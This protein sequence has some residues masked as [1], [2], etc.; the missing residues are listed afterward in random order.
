MCSGR[1]RRRPTSP[2]RRSRWA[3]PPCGSSSAS[4]RPRHA[5]LPTPPACSMWRTAVSWSSSAALGCTRPSASSP[6][7]RKSPARRGRLVA[8]GVSAVLV[9][10]VEAVVR[11]A[12]EVAEAGEDQHDRE[13][14]PPL[15]PYRDR[16]CHAKE[17]CDHGGPA[18]HGP[19][20][21]ADDL[22]SFVSPAASKGASVGV[23]AAASIQDGDA[24]EPGHDHEDREPPG[25]AAA[26]YPCCGEQERGDA[27]QQWY[28]QSWGNERDHEPDSSS[29]GSN[30]LS[31]GMSKNRA[32]RNASGSDGR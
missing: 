25:L 28:S 17:G 26:H 14:P 11:Q 1:P 19:G 27:V 6:V 7:Q 15:G 29:S 32:I 31:T 24:Y 23:S 3:R 4:S 22:Q 21:R 30:I 9:L 10:A 2:G 13:R 16:G 18:G 8:L 5:P 20:P 12:E